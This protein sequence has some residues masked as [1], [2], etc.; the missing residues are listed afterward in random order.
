MYSINK[1]AQNSVITVGYEAHESS[2]ILYRYGMWMVGT[3]SLYWPQ[4][5]PLYLQSGGLRIPL[6]HWDHPTVLKASS[7]ASF[8]T[9]WG[10]QK[11]EHQISIV[12]PGSS[13]FYQYAPIIWGH[14]AIL[15]QNS[16]KVR[17]SMVM[18]HRPANPQTWHDIG[19]LLALRA[20]FLPISSGLNLWNDI[21]CLWLDDAK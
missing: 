7:W 19:Y 9:V 21:G 20:R 11:S 5:H 14:L 13:S 4:H 12:Y 3:Y 6:T 18:I 8:A 15:K 1:H 2:L 17:T 16:Q 10:S